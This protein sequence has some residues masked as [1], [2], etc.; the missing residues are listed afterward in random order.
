VADW[1]DGRL[2]V[3]WHEAVDTCT[4]HNI[5]TILGNI[6]GFQ[7]DLFNMVFDLI[8][9]KHTHTNKNENKKYMKIK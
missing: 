7:Y 9:C 6:E 3:G 5:A 2:S 4:Q 1:H 8:L